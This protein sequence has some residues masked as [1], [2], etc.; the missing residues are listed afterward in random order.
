MSEMTFQ[1][2]HR[3]RRRWNLQKGTADHSVQIRTSSETRD[4]WVHNVMDQ[5][6]SA[7]CWL[8]KITSQSS[9]RFARKIGTTIWSHLLSIQGKRERLLS[10]VGKSEF[11]CASLAFGFGAFVFSQFSKGGRFL[12]V[13]RAHI[14]PLT[15]VAFNKSGSR[16]ECDCFMNWSF[17]GNWWNQSFQGSRL[18]ARTALPNNLCWKSNFLIWV[19]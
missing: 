2:R 19:L 4:T 9:F 7:V 10:G 18:S 16:W 8:E 1:N 15:N 12:Q 17:Q 6:Q 11:G 13:L 14:L 3:C 5:I